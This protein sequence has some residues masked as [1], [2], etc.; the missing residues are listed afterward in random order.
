[1]GSKSVEDIKVLQLCLNELLPD[2]VIDNG[3]F[4]HYT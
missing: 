3:H 1:M 2:D 4:G